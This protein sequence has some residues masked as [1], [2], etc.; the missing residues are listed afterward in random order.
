M[1]VLVA[2]EVQWTPTNVK[3]GG[4]A[5]GYHAGADHCAGGSAN[6]T[7]NTG[8][9]C[10]DNNSTN[11]DG[12]SSLCIVESGW[13]CTGTLSSC[14]KCG[15][16]TV[17]GTEGCDDGNTKSSD[18]CSSSCAVE[19]GWSCTGTPS[20]CVAASCGDGIK[21]GSEKCDDA[22]ALSGDGCSSG[23]AIESGYTCTGQ[24]SNSCKPT[25]GD[26]T[27]IGTEGC[28]DGNTT[29]SDGCSSSCIV[30]SGYTCTGTPST[31]NSKGIGGGGG[32]GETEAPI[33][34]SGPPPPCGNAITELEKCEECDKG[35]ANGASECTATCLLL[36]CGDGAIAPHLKE[37][38]EGRIEEERTHD[39]LTEKTTTRF[40]FVAAGCGMSCTLPEWLQKANGAWE[41][42]QGTGCKRDLSLPLCKGQATERRVQVRPPFSCAAASSSTPTRPPSSV[43]SRPMHCGDGILQTTEGEEC[44]RVLY[45]TAAVERIGKTL[46]GCSPACQIAHCG[47]GDITP[48]A[49]LNEECDPEHPT[50]RNGPRCATGEQMLGC[51][52]TCTRSPLPQC[53][54]SSQ[55][56]AREALSKSIDDLLQ[57]IEEEE[58]LLLEEEPDTEDEEELFE[59]EEEGEEEEGEESRE[60]IDTLEELP[61]EEEEAEEEIEGEES[62]EEVDTVEELPLPPPTTALHTAAPET[63]GAAAGKAFLLLTFLAGISATVHGAR[64][65][66]IALH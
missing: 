7:V 50:Y 48:Y 22:N 30:E 24:G 37:E 15:A 54:L 19:S 29:N 66:W 5:Y 51:S 42:V 17:G 38:C 44:D 40:W 23:C 58:E 63:P 43:A 35:R 55:E 41:Y 11:S 8:E 21:V 52:R 28:D 46:Y 27:I 12:C 13:S 25:C 47:D 1:L 33:V 53:P 39:P 61:Q 20:S 64:R 59:E 6:G 36:Y 60:D 26:S 31:C 34:P 2:V 4:I 65:L 10:D 9:G 45:D 3:K 14:S 32:G 56:Q 62:R 49:P 16:G 57:S 18:G